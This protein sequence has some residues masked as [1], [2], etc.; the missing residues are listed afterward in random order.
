MTGDEIV[1]GGYV[2]KHGQKGRETLNGGAATLF[3]VK[4]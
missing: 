2:H 1:T 4:E 3:P